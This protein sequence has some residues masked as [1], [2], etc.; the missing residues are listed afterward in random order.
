MRPFI[1][2]EYFSVFVGNL[3]TW[4]KTH[5]HINVRKAG[6]KKKL[7]NMKRLYFKPMLINKIKH[8]L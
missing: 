3:D 4:A 7:G 5:N 2:Q 6:E 8:V 1:H